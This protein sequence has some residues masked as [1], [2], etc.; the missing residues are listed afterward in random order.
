MLEEN[1]IINLSMAKC[2]WCGREYT[3][4]VH[5]WYCSEKCYQEYLASKQKS[6]Q[7]SYSGQESTGQGGGGCLSIYWKDYQ[8]DNNN[9]YSDFCSGSYLCRINIILKILS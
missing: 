1:I 2:N 3:R 9:L 6:K 4:G 7:P 5:N 8:V